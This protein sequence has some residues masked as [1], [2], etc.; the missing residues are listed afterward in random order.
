[1]KIENKDKTTIIKNTSSDI[2]SFIENIITE[3]INFKIQNLIIDL[4]TTNVTVKD[5]KLFAEA[6]K[7]HKK[8]KKSFVIVAN[9]IDYNA[10]PTKISVV[11]SIQEANDCIEMEEIERDLGF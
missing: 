3:L 10:V 2:N 9:D 1:M 7:T 6:S 5:I 4:T 8:N 11:P